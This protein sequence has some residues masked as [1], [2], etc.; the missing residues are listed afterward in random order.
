MDDREGRYDVLMDRQMSGASELEA[1]IPEAWIGQEVMIET[2]EALS[3][4]L[5]ASAPVY[6][7]DVNERGIVMLVTRHKDQSQFSRYFYPWSVV[8]WIRL[9]EEDERDK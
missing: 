2:T 1:K 9:A 8:G 6:L 7:E 3:S 4:D 5:R